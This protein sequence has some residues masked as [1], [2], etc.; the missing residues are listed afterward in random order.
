MI[1]RPLTGTILISAFYE[2]STRTSSSFQAAML[3]L[4]G[5]TISINEVHYSSVTKG[6]SLPDTVRTL[7]QTVEVDYFLPGCPP[8]ADAI[9]TFLT[10]LLEGRPIAFLYT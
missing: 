1:T 2:P 3:R 5:R 8:S 7:D 10:E 9:W 6:E 4:G